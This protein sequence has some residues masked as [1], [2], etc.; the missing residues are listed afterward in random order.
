MDSHPQCVNLLFLVY[1]FCVSKKKNILVQP[2]LCKSNSFVFF[3]SNA[4]LFNSIAGTHMF[5]LNLFNLSTLVTTHCYIEFVV[6]FIYFL[7]F[8]LVM[9]LK[10]CCKW[11]ACFIIRK[12]CYAFVFCNF[13]CMFTTDCQYHKRIFFANFPFFAFTS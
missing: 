13:N 6:K 7:S 11:M 9:N 4:E 5:H 12:M 10:L 3:F 8:Y 2:Y 1:F